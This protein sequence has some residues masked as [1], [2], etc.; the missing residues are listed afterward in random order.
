M[1]GKT[2]SYR[3][4]FTWLLLF[5]GFSGIV[6]WLGTTWLLLSNWTNS[7]QWA[8]WGSTIKLIGFHSL[9]SSFF[10]ILAVLALPW[11]IRLLRRSERKTSIVVRSLIPALVLSPLCAAMGIGTILCSPYVFAVVRAGVSGPVIVQSAYSPDGKFEAYVEEGPSIDPPNQSLF[12][13]RRDGI[14]FIQIADLPED[15][16]SIRE[17]H[18]S[19]YSDIVVFHTR[20][21]LTAVSVPGYQTVRIPLGG[22]WTWTKPTKR[23]TFSAG[24]PH[25]HVAA[26]EFPR[27]GAFSYL[28]EGS[29]KWRTIEMDVL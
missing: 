29:A 7:G 5:V 16:D 24:A 22:E 4:R 9:I 17:I 23:S 15:I 28:L 14:H 21:S 2:K 19:P 26:I 11:G 25:F 20:Y 3:D 27:K 6:G 8:T 1:S 12:I 10:L 13:Q 18:W